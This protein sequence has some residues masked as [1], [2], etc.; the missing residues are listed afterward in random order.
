MGAWY[1]L[2][3]FAEKEAKLKDTQIEVIT[4]SDQL[5]WLSY[6][7]EDLAIRSDQVKKT[8]PKFR[9]RD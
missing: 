6:F 2:D 3:A 8:G 5:P 1:R 7:V 4:V 9:S